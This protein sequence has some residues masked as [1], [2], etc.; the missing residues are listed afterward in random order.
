MQ[1]TPLTTSHIIDFAARWHGEAE[2]VG[3][4]CEGATVVS[5]WRQVARRAKLCALALRRLGVRPGDRV[6]TLGFNTVRHLECWYGIMGLGAVCHTLNPRLFEAELDFII[7]HAEGGWC[8]CGWVVYLWVGGQVAGRA[9]RLDC[10]LVACPPPGAR[11][12]PTRTPLTVAASPADT[13]IMAD[14]MFA[15]LLESL[16]AKIPSVRHLVFLC[17][18]RG[19]R[20]RHGGVARA[21]ARSANSGTLPAH[22][23]PARGPP[24]AQGGGAAP[25]IAVL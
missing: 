7:N 19:R 16:T 18:E 2:V 1:R 15:G 22:P 17:G 14:A 10:A 13:I 11:R 12:L 6:A 5:S 24:H 25:A 21:G 23:P 9:D 8:V 20:R 3:R 4:T